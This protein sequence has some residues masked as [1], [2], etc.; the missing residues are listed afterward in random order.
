MLLLQVLLVR[1]DLEDLA[2]LARMMTS[3]KLS[4]HKLLVLL[5]NRLKVLL[6]I[7]YQWLRLKKLVYH[8]LLI[9]SLFCG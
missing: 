6:T 5:R 2:G 8:Q 3:L 1:G 7:N 9:I 4:I